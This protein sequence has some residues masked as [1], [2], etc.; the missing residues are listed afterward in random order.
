MTAI[1][2]AVLPSVTSSSISVLRYSDL[3]EFMIEKGQHFCYLF[4]RTR[5]KI[6][7]SSALPLDQP[8]SSVSVIAN[9]HESLLLSSVDQLIRRGL[10]STAQQLIKRIIANSS[11]LSDAVSVFEF[12]DVRGVELDLGSYGVLIRKLVL[13]AELLFMEMESKG[14]Y[15]D[16]V[17]Y[18]TLI[19]GYCKNKKMEMAM[20]V[21][22]RMLKT[23]C[24]PDICTCNTLIQGYMKLHLYD[25][26]RAIFKQMTEWGMQPDVSTYGIMINENCKKG[27]IDYALVLLN[28]MV[29][30]MDGG[31][32]PDHVLFLILAKKFPK[33]HLLQLAL[34]ILQAIAKNGCGFDLSRLSYSASLSPSRD[35]EQEI[36]ILLEEISRRNLNLAVVAFSVCI[37]ALTMG[38]KIEIALI[39]LDR[40]LNLGCRP[41]LFTY[42]SLIKCLCQEGLFEDAKSL[43]DFMKSQGI[44][45]DHATYLIMI[46]EYCKRG[47]LE[48]AFGIMDNMDDW[49]M[50]PGVAIYDSVIGC[51]SRKKRILEAEDNFKKMLEAGVDPDEVVY[52]TMINGY[53]KNGRAVE[54]HRLFDN[55][56]ENSIRPGLISYTAL[57]SGLVKRNMT[58]EGCVYLGRML[59]DGLLPNVVLYT[60][61]ISNYLKKD[62]F[63]F[64][65]R[66]YDLMFKSQISTDHIMYS[67]LVSGVCRN[68]KRN[69]I[70]GHFPSR[71]SDKAREMLFRLLSKNTFLLKENSIGV[72]AHSSEEKKC[73][74][75]KLIQIIKETNLAPNLYLYNTIIS[76]YFLLEMMQDADHLELMRR[77]G[78]CPNQVTY[79]ILMDRHL[80][81]GDIDSGIEI[82]KKMNA[83]CCLPDRFAYNTLLRGLCKGGRLLDAL[84]LLYTMHKRGFFPNRVSY[85][86]LL[87]CF[88][89]SDLG[90][91]A[92]KIFQEMVALDYIPRQ[93]NSERLLCIL[94][95][96]INCK[97]L[98]YYGFHCIHNPVVCVFSNKFTLH[99]P[100][101]VPR[102]HLSYQAQ[103]VA[104]KSHELVPINCHDQPNQPSTVSGMAI[105]LAT[106]GCYF[107]EDEDDVA[108][109]QIHVSY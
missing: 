45:P 19:N 51:L 12:A 34:M 108:V 42:N 65:F 60:S 99:F 30:M 94:Y 25:K 101:L 92:F 52:L 75:M 84:S 89:A 102:P 71:E 88:C 72:S 79:T 8:N 78:L 66:L 62:R 80:R 64:A 106:A 56:V 69:K 73:L 105:L 5:R 36:H 46:N 15:I 11:S 50:K 91:H 100:W 109:H 107:V 104:G 21:F 4:F 28:D 96:R 39:C 95:K 3:V 2:A 35:Q 55:M 74:A 14:L 40:M 26:G 67:S 97:K 68:I 61:L 24:E 1:A 13:E 77:E 90:N 7:S 32:V 38:G 41:S 103:L 86:N 20:R 33:D 27:K 57:I 47:D 31:V 70:K 76:G 93:F 43:I 58:S 82:F 18:T 9:D 83:D 6:T 87:S 22:L 48:L 59:R 37:N 81:S 54:A 98:V 44:V 85:E 53:L 29:N 63:D 10:L 16:K 17:M 49:G 23:G